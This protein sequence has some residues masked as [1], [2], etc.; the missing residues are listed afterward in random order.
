M[1]VL[2]AEHDLGKNVYLSDW[3]AVG[4]ADIVRFRVM[5]GCYAAV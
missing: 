2:R 1:C 4:M 5:V 3:L